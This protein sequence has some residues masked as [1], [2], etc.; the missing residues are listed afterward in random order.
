M[1][2][3]LN[4]LLNYSQWFIGIFRYYKKIH[5]YMECINH[6]KDYWD[7]SIEG[8]TSQ[9]LPMNF[10]RL[11]FKLMDAFMNNRLWFNSPH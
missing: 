2:L 10:N 7:M 9:G 4:N 8:K 3:K 11:Y 6:S 5:D 1:K